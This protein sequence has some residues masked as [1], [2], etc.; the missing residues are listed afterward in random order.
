MNSDEEA[1]GT[2]EDNIV[3]VIWLLHHSGSQ[4]PVDAHFQSLHRSYATH[5]HLTSNH[6]RLCPSSVNVLKHSLFVS[7][8]LTQFCDSTAPSWTCNSSAILATLKFFWL[9]LTLWLTW[10]QDMRSSL[11]QDIHRLIMLCT[12]TATTTAAATACPR[13]TVIDRR[14][15]DHA[16]HETAHSHITT[17]QPS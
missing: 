2:R 9:T 4:L 16:I 8:F 11:Q 3:I 5:C 17:R 1:A 14:R 15:R 6:P 7:L 12:A 10:W 13:W